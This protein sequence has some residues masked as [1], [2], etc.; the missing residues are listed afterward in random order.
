[1]SGV[2]VCACEFIHLR[3]G[4]HVCVCVRVRAYVCVC[5]CVP[6]AVAMRDLLKPLR[7]SENEFMAS[8]NGLLAIATGMGPARTRTACDP[9]RLGRPAICWAM[10][11]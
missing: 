5:V 9:D 11:P 1:M 2:C 4:D 6:P 10:K 8:S 7:K 3:A